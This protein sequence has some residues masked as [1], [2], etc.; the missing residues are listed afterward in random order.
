M[1]F[2]TCSFQKDGWKATCFYL[3]DEE[4]DL[5][6]SGGKS[7]IMNFGFVNES[8]IFVDHIHFLMGLLFCFE[9]LDDCLLVTRM[10]VAPNISY[11]VTPVAPCSTSNLAYRNM[12]FPEKLGKINLCFSKYSTF[13]SQIS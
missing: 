8:H 7:D 6:T 4:T 11:R 13:T 2:C 5:V 9:P 3:N 10:C 1:Y 12:G